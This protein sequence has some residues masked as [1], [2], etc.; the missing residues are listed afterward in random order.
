[1]AENV[2]ITP[3]SGDVV[4]ADDIAGVKYQRVK[5]IHGEDGVNDGDVAQ[6]NGIPVRVGQA[7]SARALI[8]KAYTFFTGSYQD[9][10]LTSISTTSEATIVNDSDGLYY[11]SW[12]GSNNY[13]AIL[14]YMTRSLPVMDGAAALYMKYVTAP[15]VG[16]VYI[17]G[18]V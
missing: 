4:G 6:S 3:G 13:H 18:I 1:M 8:I 10:G 5:L 9:T 11:V 12:D 7:K 17:E 16:N 2:Q 14:P 15:T